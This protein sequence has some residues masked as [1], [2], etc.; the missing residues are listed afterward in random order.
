MLQTCTAST[1]QSFPSL[2]PSHC[3]HRETLNCCRCQS[4]DWTTRKEKKN[5]GQNEY[6]T[7]YLINLWPVCSSPYPSFISCCICCFLGCFLLNFYT[8][9]TCCALQLRPGGRRCGPT[10]VAGITSPT[11]SGFS[12]FYF[13]FMK[14][15]QRAAV[16]G[17]RE[18][19]LLL[20][21]AC[22][23]GTETC[24]HL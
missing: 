22:L 19:Q 24:L 11:A 6:V 5:T 9:S 13:V 7:K 15:E 1:R 8:N 14:L 16:C 23:V 12:G 3:Q 10:L 2:P 4:H 17:R 21:I 20:C 18:K